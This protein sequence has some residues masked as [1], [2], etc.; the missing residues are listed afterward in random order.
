MYWLYSVET[1]ALDGAS[2]IN[3]DHVS[4]LIVF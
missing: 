2:W 3:V 4:L 1:N